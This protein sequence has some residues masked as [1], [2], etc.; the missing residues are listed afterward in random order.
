MKRFWLPVA[1]TTFLLA[2]AALVATGIR[3]ARDEFEPRVPHRVKEYTWPVAENFRYRDYEHVGVD[4]FTFKS[5]HIEKRRIGYL[6]L[7]SFNVLVIHELIVNFFPEGGGLHKEEG[8][9]ERELFEGVLLAQDKERRGFSGVRIHGL[10]VNRLASN[11]LER[12]FSA[13]MGESALGKE[14]LSLHGTVVRSPDGR[15][16]QVGSARLLLK[17]SPALV[18]LKDGARHQVSL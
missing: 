12:V 8:P 16:E 10:T 11:T 2:V 6:T 18:Y 4:Q 15:E 14:G 9:A 7:G 17:P 3:L 1:V 5:C 13:K